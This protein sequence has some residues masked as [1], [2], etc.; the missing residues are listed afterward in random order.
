[1]V[2]TGNGTLSSGYDEH[3]EPHRLRRKG[4]LRTPQADWKRTGD[5]EAEGESYFIRQTRLASQS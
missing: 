3:D 4:T 1:M 2:C 5:I